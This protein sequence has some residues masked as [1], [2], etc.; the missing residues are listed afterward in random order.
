V[1]SRA[2][3]RHALL[4]TPDTESPARL[5][6][7]SYGFRDLRCDFRFPGSEE[8]YAVMGVDL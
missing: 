5:L 1:L 8:S 4:S 7:R 3:A 2:D 6:Y